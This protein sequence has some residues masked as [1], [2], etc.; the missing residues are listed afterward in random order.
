MDQELP[1]RDLTPICLLTFIFKTLQSL[2]L[3]AQVYSSHVTSKALV[4]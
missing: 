4:P 1:S 3:S 2:W